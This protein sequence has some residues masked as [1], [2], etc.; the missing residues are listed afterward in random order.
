MAELTRIVQQLIDWIYTAWAW[1]EAQAVYLWQLVPYHR[2]ITTTVVTWYAAGYLSWAGGVLILIWLTWTIR[3]W[4]VALVSRTHYN[5]ICELNVYL[6]RLIRLGRDN[7][8]HDLAAINTA[9]RT[10]KQHFY[11]YQ[12][13][14][15]SDN[16]LRHTM[17]ELVHQVDEDAALFDQKVEL[18]HAYRLHTMVE[19]QRDRFPT[20]IRWL[21]RL[22]GGRG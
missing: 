4:L 1:L 21:Y 14:I 19:A 18:K 3:Q 7:A 17:R 10:L 20:Y 22:T 2:V 8:H 9:R 6:L 5:R 13:A 11:T 15:T 12:L 16:E